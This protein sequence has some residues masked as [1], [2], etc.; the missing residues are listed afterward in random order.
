MFLPLDQLPQLEEG[1]FYFHEIIGFQVE[2][3]NEG[4]LGTVKDVYEAGEQYLIAMNYQD[5]EVL[6]PLNDDIIPKVNKE[7]KIVHTRLPEGL[8]DVYLE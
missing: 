8:L 3:E 4:P 6:I 2:D 5:R 7:K 1:Q